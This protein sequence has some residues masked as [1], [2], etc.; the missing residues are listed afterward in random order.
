MAAF[1][2]A[3]STLTLI[4][5]VPAHANTSQRTTFLLSRA[6]DGTFPNGDSR[7]A[8]VSHDQRIARVMAYESDASNI[9]NGDANNTTDVF[10]VRRQAPWGQDGAPWSMGGDRAA[11]TGMGAPRPT[12]PRSSRRSTVTRIT[13]QAASRSSRRASNLVP[14]ENYRQPDVFVR[15]SS[16]RR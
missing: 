4:F 9:V 1:T 11:S 2:V 7:N 5:T 8:A 13:P 16:Q 14:G 15:S 12:G 3:L 6:A 10:I